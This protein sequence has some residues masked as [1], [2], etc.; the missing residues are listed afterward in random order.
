MGMPYV[1]IHTT[2]GYLCLNEN[3]TAVLSNLPYRWRLPVYDPSSTFSSYVWAGD[4]VVVCDKKLLAETGRAPFAVSQHAQNPLT[5]EYAGSV[6]EAPVY[7]IK[8]QG[9]GIHRRNFV[10]PLADGIV[11]FYDC[12]SSN[13]FYD[14]GN[15][16][17]W[18]VKV[19]D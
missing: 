11:R 6:S 17:V 15:R 19:A 3:G 7:V 1:T 12:D 2:G 9:L 18:E 5:F 13:R 10:A 16:V 8:A 4:Q 14:W